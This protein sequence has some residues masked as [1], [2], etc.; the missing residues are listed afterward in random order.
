MSKTGVGCI[1]KITQSDSDVFMAEFDD[2]GWEKDGFN[3]GGLS[4]VDSA[5]GGLRSEETPSAG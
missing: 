4:L 1:S 2:Q 5:D 3:L